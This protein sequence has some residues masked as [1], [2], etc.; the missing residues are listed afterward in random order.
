MTI[1]DL[2]AGGAAVQSLRRF[3]VE[4]EVSVRF[5]LPDGTDAEP[6]FVRCLVV[7]CIED[8]ADSIGPNRIGLH[9]LDLTEDDFERI[10]RFVWERLSQLD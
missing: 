3:E 9:F 8:T 10:R 2:S 5:Q 7:R 4:S 6:V 1:R